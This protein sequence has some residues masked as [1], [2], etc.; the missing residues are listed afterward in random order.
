L[1]ILTQSFIKTDPRLLQL[2]RL[3]V[4]I[5]MPNKYLLG[6]SDEMMAQIEK[7]ED[8]HCLLKLHQTV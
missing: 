3:W 6:L 4:R 7:D 2:Q 8:L 5:D 1:Q